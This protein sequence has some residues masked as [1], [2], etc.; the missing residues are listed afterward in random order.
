M[1]RW[2]PKLHEIRKKHYNNISEPVCKEIYIV[3]IVSRH[4]RKQHDC[5]RTNSRGLSRNQYSIHDM[6]SLFEYITEILFFK[7]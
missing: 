6:Q 1:Y 3:L 5:H 2:I 7:V 4:I